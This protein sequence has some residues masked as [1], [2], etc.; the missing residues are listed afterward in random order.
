M[1]LEDG[2]VAGMV[3]RQEMSLEDLRPLLCR[4]DAKLPILQARE[5][6]CY[7]NA[8]STIMM[9][10]DPSTVSLTLYFAAVQCV[11]HARRPRPTTTPDD[12]TR[13]PHPTTTRLSNSSCA[14]AAVCAHSSAQFGTAHS[15]AKCTFSKPRH[16]CS[17][18]V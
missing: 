8:T 5:T 14:D 2:R 10:V 6:L 11:D 7:S 18:W 17:S 1:V 3:I 13:R 9:V 12:H 4:G 15:S 16:A